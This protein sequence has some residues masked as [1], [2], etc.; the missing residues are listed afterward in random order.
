MRKTSPDPNY[1]AAAA[2]AANA[3]AEEMRE[4]RG[5]VSRQTGLVRRLKKFSFPL[6]AQRLAGLLIRPEHQTAT[7]RIEALIH[8]AAFA[9]R[10]KQ[11]PALRQLRE[12]LNV[13][14]FKDPI[15]KLEGPIEDV[16]VSNVVTH[17][18]NARLFEGRWQNNGDYVQVCVEALLR[19]AE[20]AW[21]AETLRQ[22][23]A[24]LQVSDAV[25]ERGKVARNSRTESSPRDRITIN[26]STVT[27]SIGHVSFSNDELI[28]IGVDPGDLDPFVFQ[29]EYADLLVR[30]S[31]GYTALERRPLVRF[32]GR[33]M[34]VLPTAIGAA[35]RRFV[36]ERAAATGN[37][38]MFQSICHQAQFG[39]VFLLGRAAWEIKYIEALKHDPDDDL[40]EFVGTF[41][42]GGYVHLVFVPDD[43]EEIVQEG[44]V[45]IHKV[46]GMIQDRIHDRAT[47]LAAEPDY[48]RGLTVLVHG[49]I[50]REFSPL[51]GDLPSGWHQLCLSAPDF[52]LLGNESEFTAMRAWKLLQQVDDL[53]RKGVVFPNLRGFLNL[54]AFAY[55]G[56]FELVPVN[57]NLAP[58]YLHSDFILPLRHRVRAA[59]D[60]HA[61]VA[62][63]S[64]S[65]ANV[66]RE[67]TGGFLG[68]PQG[69]PVFISPAHMTQRELLAC[70][71]ATG[72]PWW[73]RC[74]DPPESGWHHSVV[75]N[76]L[77][78]VLGWLVR[79][80]PL[81]EARLP[82]LPS[83]PVAYRF[84]FPDIG[85]L[86]QDDPETA[87][88]PAALPVAVEEGE[89][90]IDCTP[91]Y[92]RNFLS[93]DN[94]GDRLMIA[95]MLRGAHV[96][97]GNRPP[98]D[99]EMD[100]L[101]HIVVGSNDARF[102]QMTPSGAP[103]DMIYDVAALPSPRLLMPEDQAWSRLDLVRR[104]GYKSAPGPIPAHE[105]GSIL[106]KAVDTAWGR[107][108]SRLTN[109]S[110]E[111][112]IECSLLNFVTLQKEH[113]DWYRTAAAQLAL[114]D[115]AEVV[116]AANDRAFRRDT[117]GL[118]CRV[119]A[120]M[121][122]CTSPYRG[123]SACTGTDLD[124]LIAEV[125]TLLECAHESDA[126]HYSLAARP[127][128]MHANGSF[129]FH[130]STAK[131]I[132]P[133]LEE[134]GTRIFLDAA[135]NQGNGLGGGVKGEIADPHFEEAFV[136][137]FGLSIEDYGKFVYHLTL[138]TLERPRAFLRLRKSE[139]VQRL[140][141]AGG[142]NPKEVFDAFVLT[143]RARWDEKS[144]AK[145]RA[146]DWYP[147]R[148]NRRLSIMRR[149]LVQYSTEDDPEVLVMPSILAGTLD[150][151]QEASFGRLP[152]GLFDGP[153]MISCIGRAADR[154]GH[155]FNRRVAL[156]I[157]ELG[158]K[159][160]QEVSL[161]QL[162]GEAELGDIDVLAWQ[163]DRSLVYA[164]E[165]KSLRFDRTWGEIGERLAEYST[166][167]VDGKRT[168][169]Q[170]H[171]DR[172]SYLGGNREWLSHHTDIPIE[173]LQLR[174][175]LVT[176][177]LVPMQFAGKARQMLNLVTDYELLE[178]AFGDG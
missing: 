89:V 166:G 109:L 1:D 37:L 101:V 105:A 45:S 162:G 34:A 157:G 107:I 123:R 174:S 30:Q 116:A 70:V 57:M 40:R 4:I 39:E 175:A 50:G 25:A 24:M 75:F 82:V 14:I 125:A 138:E 106:G 68:E 87:V 3:T 121:A 172:I 15:A 12:W 173:R 48:R 114:Y 94:L 77:E 148:Y 145:A 84:R 95:A 71:E 152:E 112:V 6:V 38:G 153:E 69:R 103:Q 32:E 85:T 110:R 20:Q 118:A 160:E 108:R 143:P 18:G 158:W 61:A 129:G 147:W 29:E 146:K 81:L 62:P 90:V 115:N 56:D 139:V 155:D 49:G 178:E 22:V 86:S 55:Y 35:I 149:P 83:E 9:C 67:T 60:R 31:I 5:L 88:M 72:R 137:E 92:L 91:A 132:S 113:R 65:W 66:Q 151:L 163:P 96:L 98:A 159:T 7:V 168:P 19:M 78:M 99:R 58:I 169:L 42:D 79:L 46:K 134:H 117:A 73:I 154:N 51:W 76:I 59:L 150:Y 17:F 26:V 10:G 54:A 44:F 170:K 33:T 111:S 122:L 144:P 53:E 161:T 43:F 142:M 130:P 100:E 171:L 63:D 93:D 36:I 74:S 41:D 8:V 133:L 104:A 23:T 136:D 16:F 52:M 156:R 64:V 102:F 131:A 135:V 176:E 177:K 2:L 47:C 11:E 80:A 167:T 164:I 120:E 141:E 21:A 126:L 140:G 27:E 127:P 13:L 128:V 119:I 97:G 165:C 28:A 124:F